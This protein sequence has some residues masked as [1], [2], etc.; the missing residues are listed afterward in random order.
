MKNNLAIVIPNWNGGKMLA[1][2]LASLQA[3]TVK[4]KIVVVD[5]G[6]VDESVEI[7]KRF[8]GVIVIEN[9]KNEGFAGGVNPGLRWAL[10]NDYQFI[11]LFNNDAVA[12]ETWAEEII[13]IHKKHSGA[14]GVAG[15][16]LKRDGKTIDS[17]GDLYSVWGLPI[18]RQ[19]NEKTSLAID[20]VEAVFGATAGACIYKSKAVRDV[21]FF[22]ERFFAYYE[23]T[24][25]NFRL[26]LAGWKN[27]YTPGA[28]AYHAIGA[29]SGKM[30]G[31]T[32]YQTLKNLPMLF[33]KTVPARL[34]PKMLPR[35][36]IAYSFI[37]L[38]S[39]VRGRARPALKGFFVYLK[40][41]PHI[42]LS[43]RKIQ[44]NKRVTN[45]YVRSIIFYDLP[46]DA[47]RLRRMRRI[48]TG[49]A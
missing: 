13:K 27:F 16:L 10:E 1:D 33:W 35:F 43:R 11:G 31:F 17:T 29:T 28:V 15:K 38:S 44:K 36:F 12:E 41:I 23:D 49:K 46:P 5:N 4:P 21:G 7:A 37:L 30:S 8:K 45:D 40:N 2:C 6:S 14:G 34:L 42:Y 48:F 3:Q 19:R 32:T 22:D 18:A 25:Y 26:Q 39:V 47:H 24:D 20:K 9:Q